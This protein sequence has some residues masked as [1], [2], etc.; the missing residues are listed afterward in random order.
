MNTIDAIKYRDKYP[1]KYQARIKSMY[2]PK[3]KGFVNHHWSYNPEHYK[4]IIILSDKD[5]KK[6]HRNMTYDPSLMI[7]YDRS[8]NLLDTRRKHIEYAIFVKKYLSDT[9]GKLPEIEYVIGNT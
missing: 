6:L 2:L 5:H 1:E 9:N 7:Y 8:G 4:D 3:K